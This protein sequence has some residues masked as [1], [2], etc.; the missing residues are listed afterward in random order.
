MNY[1]EIVLYIYD[2]PSVLYLYQRPDTG[3]VFRAFASKRERKDFYAEFE[4]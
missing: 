2:R 3:I 4:S 1:E